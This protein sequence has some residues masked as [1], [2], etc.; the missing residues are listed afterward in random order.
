MDAADDAFV[1]SGVVSA[2]DLD[3]DYLRRCNLSEQEQEP[4]D[5]QR[6]RHCA[7]EVE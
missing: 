1:R 3:P 4:T 6:P 7:V 5:L 2:S